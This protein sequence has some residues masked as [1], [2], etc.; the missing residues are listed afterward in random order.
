MPGG[1]LHKPIWSPYGLYGEID[2]MYGFKQYNLHTG[3]TSAQGTVNAMETFAY[4]VYLYLV[5]AYGEQ[6]ARQGTGAPD[7]SMMGQFRA[8]SESRT[9]YGKVG[10]WAAVLGYSVA[11]VTFWKTV[12]YWMN[13][14][15]SGILVCNLILRFGANES[16][17]LKI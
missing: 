2:H 12:L 11:Q 16:Q 6:E 10:A 9:V 14:A 7:K 17:A 13:E 4:G 15:F 5:Y 1:F 8:L 3:W